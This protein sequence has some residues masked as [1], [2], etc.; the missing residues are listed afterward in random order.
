MLI[1]LIGKRLYEIET[2]WLGVGRGAKYIKH[3]AAGN[4]VGRF[5]IDEENGLII[6]IQNGG[7]LTVSDLFSER[8]LWA[9]DKVHSI[10]RLKR[11]LL[12]GFIILINIG[13]PFRT[14]PL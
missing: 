5:K 3:R 8:L 7:G 10:Q 2:N 11:R 9:L 13:I 6:A 12:I 14:R 4:N 1:F